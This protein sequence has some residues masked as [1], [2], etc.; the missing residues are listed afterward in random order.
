MKIKPNIH[1]LMG[2][3]RRLPDPLSEKIIQGDVKPFQRGHGLWVR[4]R[5]P[6]P[7][8][9]VVGTTT[10]FDG[11]PPNFKDHWYIA[12]LDNSGNVLDQVRIK[13]SLQKHYE[14]PPDAHSENI[15]TVTVKKDLGS[16]PFV[17]TRGVGDLEFTLDDCNIFREPPNFLLVDYKHTVNQKSDDLI[18]CTSSRD[19][20]NELMAIYYYNGVG[21][22]D[23]PIGGDHIVPIFSDQ[24]FYGNDHM[25][26]LSGELLPLGLPPVSYTRDNIN[27]YPL[28][29]VQGMALYL[30]YKTCTTLKQHYKN[31]G[32]L[33]R[34]TSCMEELLTESIRCKNVDGRELHLTTYVNA[35]TAR[36]QRVI[37]MVLASAIKYVIEKDHFIEQQQANI[38]AGNDGDFFKEFVNRQEGIAMG[39]GFSQFDVLAMRA[40]TADLSSV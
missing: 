38:D 22:I 31:Q 32:N 11:N 25:G 19:R 12:M 35:G 28:P 6:S 30:A 26:V 20:L 14:I 8:S 4:D 13:T 10:D 1:Y 23:T 24:P 29:Y 2:L 27:D 5:R 37:S 34:F 15:G 9:I 17:L 7:P 39:L 3:N 18:Y 16:A 33:D 21:V 36:P 40:L